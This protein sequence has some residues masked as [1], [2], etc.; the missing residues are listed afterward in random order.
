MNGGSDDKVIQLKGGS[1][2]TLDVILSDTPWFGEKA[3]T[4][5]PIESELNGAINKTLPILYSPFV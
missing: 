4:E 5:P 2:M 3:E 1:T